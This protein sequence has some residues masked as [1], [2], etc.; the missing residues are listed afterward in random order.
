MN[1]RRRRKNR[2]GMNIFPLVDVV[3]M[4]LI[5]FMLTSKFITQTTHSINLPKSITS[6]KLDKEPIVVYV[7][8]DEKVYFNKEKQPT[9]MADL[10]RKVSDALSEYEKKPSVVIKGDDKISLGLTIRL[11]DVVKAAGGESVDIT[12]IKAGTE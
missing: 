1:I 4:L 3:L 7:T 2:A 6:K 10:Q 11:L 12:T 9:A 5:F 8:K